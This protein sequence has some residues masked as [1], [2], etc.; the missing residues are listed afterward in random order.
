MEKEILSPLE[1]EDRENDIDEFVVPGLSIEGMDYK[2][3]LERLRSRDSESVA[4]ENSNEILKEGKLQKNPKK[5]AKVP[6][7]KRM[8]QLV[9]REKRVTIVTSM[10]VWKALKIIA[11]TEGKTVSTFLNDFI[12]ASFEKRIEHASR[13]S[14]GQNL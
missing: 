8:E 13:F 1:R 2:A 7:K 10:A 6:K 11:A 14:D 12:E 4:K 9:K 5:G 3:Y